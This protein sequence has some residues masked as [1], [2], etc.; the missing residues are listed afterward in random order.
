M[1]RQEL[2]AAIA[3]NGLLP[4]MTDNTPAPF[5][6]LLRLMSTWHIFSHL[7]CP[8]MHRQELA[9]A[10]ATDA[11]LPLMKDNTPAP[12]AALLKACW[13]LDPAQRP[14]AQQMLQELQCIQ[15]HLLPSSGNQAAAAQQSAEGRE[16]ELALCNPMYVLLSLV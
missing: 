1:H 4:L 5:A 16:G 12:F 7:H 9:A 11:L 15:Q 6:A 13:S 14:S 8:C 2:A 10:I 3:T